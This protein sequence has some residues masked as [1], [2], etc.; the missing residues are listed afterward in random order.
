MWL[1]LATIGIV[2][3]WLLINYRILVPALKRKRALRYQKICPE[4][5]LPALS[6]NLDTTVKVTSR[7]NNPVHYKVN[8][9]R[10]TCT[11]SRFRRQRGYYPDQDIR[12]L[13]RHLRRALESE[14]V[15]DQY[16]ELTRKIIQERV[17]DKCY[18][19]DTVLGTEVA[20]GFHPKQEFMRVYA[21]RRG[22]QDGPNGPFTGTYE[23]FS[24]NINQESWIYGEAPPGATELITRAKAILAQVKA[25]LPD[26]D[27]DDSDKETDA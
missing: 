23:K 16:D 10:L 11:C 13:C 18:Q 9:Y 21:R 8:L 19:R 26:S 14:N 3:I 6:P 2:G 1:L 24:L 4:F 20:F 5:F 17:R 7:S 27:K 12:R 15:L 25:Q 22:Q